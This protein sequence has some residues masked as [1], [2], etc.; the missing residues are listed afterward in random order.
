MNADLDEKTITLE[1]GDV[2]M[3]L[4]ILDF[5]ITYFRKVVRCIDSQEYKKQL[6]RSETMHKDLMDSLGKKWREK[7]KISG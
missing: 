4:E 2:T 7:I 1:S 5:N 6:T 3:F